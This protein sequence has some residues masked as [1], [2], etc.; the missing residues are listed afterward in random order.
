MTDAAES[1]ASS[2]DTERRPLL[3]RRAIFLVHATTFVLAQVLLFATWDLQ[4]WLGGTDNPWF[5]YVLVVCGVGLAAHYAATRDDPGAPAAPGKPRMRVKKA[6]AS[7][8]AVLGLLIG[9]TY[10]VLE[11]PWSDYSLIDML[12]LFDS[13]KLAYNFQHLDQIFPAEPVTAA[14]MPYELPREAARDLPV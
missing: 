14:P 8:V 12:T 13:D 1:A 3:R 9:G 7:L 4:R 2:A 11:R 5:L 10:L 6:A